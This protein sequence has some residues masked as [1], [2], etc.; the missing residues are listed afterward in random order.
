MFRNVLLRVS[1]G[2]FTLFFLSSAY[3]CQGQDVGGS[4]GDDNEEWFLAVTYAA[5]CSPGKTPVGV[6]NKNMDKF[7]SLLDKVADIDVKSKSYPGSNALMI[8]IHPNNPK[9]FD[10]L[11]EHG[12][13]VNARDDEGVT[14]LMYAANMG[15]VRAAKILLENGANI[16][17]VSN[18]GQTA[19][20]IA[21]ARG[22]D[23]VNLLLEYG[24]DVNVKGADNET[25]LMSA[26]I[27]GSEDTIKIL[28]DKGADVAVAD[29]EGNTALAYA[30]KFNREDIVTMLKNA[31]AVD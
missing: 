3:L 21:A 12:A 8:A 19:L 27:L 1:T 23:I 14:V 5:T 11:L 29:R 15:N 2:M 10:L 18:A 9:V 24:A 4:A 26:V 25:A 17:D 22:F 31:G 28:L 13:N 20:I 16:N 30:K 7:L 6:V